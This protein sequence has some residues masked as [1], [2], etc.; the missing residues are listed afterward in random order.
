MFFLRK[1]LLNAKSE[2]LGRLVNPSWTGE[3]ELAACQAV[4]M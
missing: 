2:G 3:A 4:W 1:R